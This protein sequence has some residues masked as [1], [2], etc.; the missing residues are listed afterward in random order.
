MA[1]RFIFTLISIE[2]S[3]SLGW[4]WQRAVQLP[5]FPLG[6]KA[7]FLIVDNRAFSRLPGIEHFDLYGLQGLHSLVEI[8]R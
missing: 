3:V 6:I 2:G 4:V 5:T 7:P 1:L 8:G